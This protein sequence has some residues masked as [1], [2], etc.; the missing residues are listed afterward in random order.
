MTEAMMARTAQ[1]FPVLS[2]AQIARVSAIGKRMEIS[3]GEVLFEVGEQNTRFFVILAG[4]VEVMLP[5]ADREQTVVVHGPGQFT[6][7]INMLSARRSLVRGRVRE[8]GAVIAVDRRDLRLLVQRD[9]EL[10][11]ILLR[12]FILRRVA[13]LSEGS[14]LILLGSQHSADTLRIREFLSRNGQPFV[15]QDVETDPS[16]QALL[17]SFHIGVEEVPVI[18]CGGGHVLKNPSLEGLATSLGL[19]GTLDPNEVRDVVIVGAGPAGLAAA[20]YGASEGLDVLVLDSTAAGGQA[21]TSS[22]IEN[23][24]GFPTGISGQ[25]L[26]GRARTQAEKFGA[27]VVVGR[28]VVRLDCDSRP[29]RLFLADGQVLRTRTIVI[30]SGVQYRRLDLPMLARFE[31]AGVF[32]SATHLEGQLCQGETVA[33]VG[34]GNSAGQA[35][36][37]LSQLASHVHVLVRGP[38]LAESMSRYLI[39]RIESSPNITLRTRSVIDELAGGDHL[40]SVRWRHLDT[41]EQETHPIRNVFSM[42]GA[43]PN[44]GWLA[45]C[46]L[47][48]D[49]KFVKTGVDLLPEDL[50]ASGWR[51]PRRPYLM[52]TSIPGVFCVGD[53]RA[54]SVKRVA[55]AVGEGSICVQLVHRA[56]QEL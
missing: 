27:E 20:V 6:G 43:D 32:Y 13:L 50:K 24:L 34:G 4:T 51:L 25:A 8:A 39:Q 1:M 21:G 22:R 46:L 16:V 12:A 3:A 54:N 37:F 56:L 55:S 52:E 35:A 31:G 53:A 7:E 36:V 14:D 42:T 29:Y 30:A 45:G 9:S 19:A 2:E 28:N 15:Y 10:S 18:V 44:T 47:M 48:D 41:G 33:V 5:V 49:K 38:G 11:E 40:E 17:D 26:A 23:Y